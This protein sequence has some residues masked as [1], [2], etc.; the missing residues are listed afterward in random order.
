MTLADAG[1]ERTRILEIWSLS[2]PGFE[3]LA[4]IAADDTNCTSGQ[5]AIKLLHAI[6]EEGLTLDR[7]PQ[8]TMH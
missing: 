6:K 5:F 4:A 3:A 1:A 2:V 8:P 7:L